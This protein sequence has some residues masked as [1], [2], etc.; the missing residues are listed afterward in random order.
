MVTNQIKIRMQN[1]IA[2]CFGKHSYEWKQCQHGNIKTVKCEWK[3]CQ[4]GNIKTVK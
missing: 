1:F 2:F 4:H 3:Q